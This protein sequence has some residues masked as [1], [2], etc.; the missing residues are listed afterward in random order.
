[1]HDYPID[2]KTPDWSF[3]GDVAQPTG[4]VELVNYSGSDL[5]SAFR[6]NVCLQGQVERHDLPYAIGLFPHFFHPS[7]QTRSSSACSVATPH[8][9]RSTRW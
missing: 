7:T 4:V 9:L 3:I 8:C 5:T 6:R 2:G 1:M